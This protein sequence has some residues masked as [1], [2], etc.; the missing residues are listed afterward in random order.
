MT[1]VHVITCS[2]VWNSSSTCGICI[3]LINSMMRLQNH[4]HTE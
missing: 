3:K 4:V 1:S 2:K